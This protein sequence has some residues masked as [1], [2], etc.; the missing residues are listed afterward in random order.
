MQDIP[1][2]AARRNSE[3]KEPDYTAITLLDKWKFVKQAIADKRLTAG[4]IRCVVAIADCYNSGKGR[5]W[6]SYSYISR[7][8]GLSRSAIARSVGKLHALDII[9]KVS[10]GTGRANTYRPAFR[11]PSAE[12]NSP[13]AAD[14]SVTHET[15]ITHETTPVSC[16][17][18]DP[19]RVSDTIPLTPRSI[20]GGE[21][22]GIPTDGGATRAWGALRPVGGAPE[23]DGFE[24]FWANY[25]KREGRTLAKQAY[26]RVVA[27]G[28][29]PDT[30]IA[31]ARQYA[32]AKAAVDAKWL[33][34]PANWLKEECWLEDPQPP[35]PREPKPARAAESHSAKGKRQKPAR[36][37][38]VVKKPVVNSDR[39]VVKKL[40][41]AKPVANGQTD[42]GRARLKRE[43]SP[44]PPKPLAI[45]EPAKPAPKP[46]TSALGQVPFTTGAIADGS[47]LPR[48]AI[49]SDAPKPMTRAVSQS[50]ATSTTNLS[51]IVS[52]PLLKSAPAAATA[53]N[54]VIASAL[55]QATQPFTPGAIAAEAPKPAPPSPLPVRPVIPPLKAPWFEPGESVLHEDYYDGRVILGSESLDDND[56]K[57]LIE[58]DDG[59]HEGP[60]RHLLVDPAELMLTRIWHSECG[61]GTFL[62]ED[63]DGEV[64]VI[65]D[66]KD[67][68][69]HV[70]AAEL[71]PCVAFDP[72]SLA[73]RD[74]KMVRHPKLGHG[75]VVGQ[76]KA[77]KLIVVF[78]DK[79]GSTNAAE[80]STCPPAA[81]KSVAETK[82]P[83]PAIAAALGQAEKPFT[84]SAIADE[85]QKLAPAAATAPEHA[86]VPVP[87]HV[88]FTLGS[89]TADAPTRGSV[90]E[91]NPKHA[92]SSAPGRCR[93]RLAQSQPRRRSFRSKIRCFSVLR[94]A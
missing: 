8:T 57:V 83:E 2:A 89:I 40:A 94:V 93:S 24:Q 41:R 34:M 53:P 6:P 48:P 21:Y 39:P 68:S 38:P 52:E 12:I 64:S 69:S 20:S 66:D 49:R 80:L 17:T 36:A 91:I 35:R 10:G 55:E 58:F 82:T 5:A 14:T 74:G 27:D 44:P 62:F 33:K 79:D 47:K 59:S 25:P 42:K 4:D 70:M 71:S 88:P 86:I 87:G 23:N 78:D 3:A 50:T 18:P 37:K 28:I 60:G 32:E 73:D 13:H 31:K 51:G 65:F 72:K 63:E 30:L 84:P 15:G 81:A 75:V 7:Q 90:A 45:A 56:G 9:H 1:R 26:S 16:M 61:L 11:E 77:G 67:G 43:L 19:S 85:A 76:E 46:A 92:I 29:A 54:R 22:R